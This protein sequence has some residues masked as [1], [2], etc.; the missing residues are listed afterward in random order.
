VHRR[1]D[2]AL[3]CTSPRSGAARPGGVGDG[4]LTLKEQLDA[5][6]RGLIARARSA[7][8]E[9][10]SEAAPRLGMSRGTLIDRLHRYGIG[11]GSEGDDAKRE[12]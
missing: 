5:L 9:N 6:E 7:A 2:I 3:A 8:G 4:D 10:Q 1:R 11:P 12:M